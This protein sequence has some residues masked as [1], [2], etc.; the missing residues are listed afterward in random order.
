M[1]DGT[2]TEKGVKAGW[3]DDKFV[4]NSRANAMCMTGELHVAGVA[5]VLCEAQRERSSEP[6]RPKEG[7]AAARWRARFGPI[8]IILFRG[9]GGRRG[10]AEMVQTVATPTME[11]VEEEVK[12][13]VCRG[14]SAQRRG[15]KGNR[16][17]TALQYAMRCAAAALRC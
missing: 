13:K 6:P 5:G 4:L 17:R 7:A 8:F 11:E 3:P 9:G 2:P 1:E 16:E 15:E 14:Q 10:G 12:K